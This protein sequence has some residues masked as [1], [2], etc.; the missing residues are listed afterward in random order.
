MAYT[1]INKSTDYFNT[2]L[3]TGTGS[4]QVITGVGF[5]PDLIWTA[6][7]NESEIRPLNDSV[8]GINNYLRSNAT[9]TLETSGSNITA[10]S[11]DGYTVGTENRFNQSSNTFVS[12]NWKANGQGSANTDGTVN[13]TYTSASS[14]SGF[15]IVKWTHTTSG[16]YTV[17]HGLNATPKM[18]I[19]KTTNAT[20]NWGV[21]HSGLT[22]GKRVILNTTSA[23]TTGYW[24]A[25]SWTNN[26]FSIGSGRDDNGKTMIAYCFAEKTGFSKFGKYVGN[27]NNDGSF[28]YTGFAPSFMMT[29]RIDSGN[30][31]YMY[32]RKT[33]TTGGNLTDKYLE[34]NENSAEATTTGEYGFDFLSN[35]F[36]ATG[37]GGGTN[38]N[39]GNYIFMAF[40]EAPLVGSNNQPANA[41]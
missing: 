18:I 19:V 4:S 34:A 33:S 3:Y 27:G 39:N 21:Y 26:T 31:W 32:S 14:T 38:A 35:G 12:W 2:K 28:T 24:G 22:V 1:T 17:G 15:S 5:Q 36:K 6:T 9:D 8:N 13:S 37:T 10:Q 41:R 16:N 40:A 29:K 7:R 23:E 20:T 25:N 11:S 30:S